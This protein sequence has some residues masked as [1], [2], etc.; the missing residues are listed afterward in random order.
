M[1]SSLLGSC[2]NGRRQ[3]CRGRAIRTWSRACL[4]IQAYPL[5]S[6]AFESRLAASHAS[7]LGL[8]GSSSASS[9]AAG[10]RTIP[11][12]VLFQPAFTHASP[13]TII[14][15]IPHPFQKAISLLPLSLTSQAPYQA[16]VIVDRQLGEAH[17]RTQSRYDLLG[18]GPHIF[19]CSFDVLA[20]LRTLASHPLDAASLSRQASLS[21]WPYCARLHFDT[22]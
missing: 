17:T 8:A 5:A 6:P 15:S 19:R 9:D 13:S 10:Q 22:A 20:P 18:L 1:L 2:W 14:Q 7:T 21:G 3:R 12:S 16:I 11:S 4:V